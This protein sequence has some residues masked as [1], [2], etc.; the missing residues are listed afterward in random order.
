MSEYIITKDHI[1]R[2]LI[3]GRENTRTRHWYI[4]STNAGFF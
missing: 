4:Y 2:Q 3:I 1:D